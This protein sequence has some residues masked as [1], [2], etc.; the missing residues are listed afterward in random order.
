MRGEGNLPHRRRG[1]RV[2]NGKA[3]AAKPDDGA[4]CARIDS[5]VVGIVA[6]PDD[7]G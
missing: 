4:A 6:E 3:A 1:R 7:A 2:E 5:Y